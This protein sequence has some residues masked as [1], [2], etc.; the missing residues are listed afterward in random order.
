MKEDRCSARFPYLKGKTL[1]EILGEEIRAGKAPLEAIRK[2]LDKLYDVNP[3]F[4]LP[5]QVT[6]EILEVFGELE[7]VEMITG[8]A[9][10]I[11]NVDGLFENMMETRR[12]CS[13]WTMSGS[14]IS[15]FQ[16]HLYSSVR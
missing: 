1:S 9:C 5:F 2:A 16:R 8:D 4:V 11:S 10:Q 7:G 14:L 15:R 12:D 13:A 3:D 6:Q